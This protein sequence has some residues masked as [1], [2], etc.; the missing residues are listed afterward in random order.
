[1]PEVAHSVRDDVVMAPGLSDYPNQVKN[2][3]CFPCIV[4]GAL[5]H[6]QREMPATFA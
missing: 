1:M 3:L 4:R 6:D 2:V 5:D